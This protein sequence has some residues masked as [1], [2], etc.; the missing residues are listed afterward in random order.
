[1]E[2]VHRNDVYKF[3]KDMP[4]E[5]QLEIISKNKQRIKKPPGLTPTESESKTGGKTNEKSTT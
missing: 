3:F 2:N 4:I 5:M 1:M